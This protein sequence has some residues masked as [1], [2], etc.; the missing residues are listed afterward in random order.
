MKWYE[1][2][3][4]RLAIEKRLLAAYHRG[5][6]MCI[7]HGQIHVIKSIAGRYGTYVVRGTFS[8]QHPY[9][10]M[11]FEIVSPA[12]KRSPP[13]RYTGG[14]LCLH[15]PGDV[16]PETTAKVYLDWAEQWIQIYED[17][18]DGKPWPDTNRD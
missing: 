10:P 9:A 7:K 4:E 3:P 2:N 1:R 8:D 13:H 11:E 12:L 14:Q 17:W 5:V 15:D 18:L 6:K 16:G